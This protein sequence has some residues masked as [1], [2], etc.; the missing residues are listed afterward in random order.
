[1]EENKINSNL[2]ASGLPPLYA[3][4]RAKEQELMPLIKHPLNFIH[5]RFLRRSSRK[6]QDTTV[7]AG[8]TGEATNALTADGEVKKERESGYPVIL[9]KE[10]I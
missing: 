8:T 2:I 7:D 1:M 3:E 10:Q 5:K 4:K 6:L 9:T